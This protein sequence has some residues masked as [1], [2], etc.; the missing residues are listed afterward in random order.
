MV[1]R[2]PDDLGTVQLGMDYGIAN[3]QGKPDYRKAAAIVEAA[4]SGGIRHFD[5]AQSYGDSEAVL[6][7]VL[8]DLGVALEARVASKLSVQL[9]PANAAEVEASIE[10]A[11]K[12]LRVDHLW[13]MML[14]RAN[15][16]DFWD[17]GLGALLLRYRECGRIRHLGVSL[18]SPAEA[19]R[20]LA[21]PHMEVLQIACNAWDRRMGRLGVLDTAR[22]GGRLC[23]ARSIYL[24]GL[25]TISEEAVAV[26]LPRARDAAARWH[27]FCAA[28]AIPPVEFAVRFASGLGVPL[29]V[30]A[31]SPEQIR[32]TLALMQR[33]PLPKST[34]IELGETMDPVLS[35]DLLDP[36]RWPVKE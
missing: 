8:H 12:R 25:L 26:R 5:T 7:A 2:Y 23:C 9:D 10:G 3:T 14:H 11:L 21:H 15:W 22:A 27:A 33:D 18:S 31:E 36:W 20:C 28:R 6:G 34:V 1:S 32:G 19:A 35:E 29:V 13:C 30:G 17:Q 16:L 4:W 24:Q